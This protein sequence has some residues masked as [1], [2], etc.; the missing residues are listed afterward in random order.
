MSFN[1]SG[2]IGRAPGDSAITLAK[3]YFQP[4]GVTTDFTFSSGYSPGLVDVYRNGVKLIN[5]LDYAATDGSTISLS[6]PVGVGSTVQ[7]VAYK[8]FNLATVKA[9]E[10]DTTVTGTTINLGGNITAANATISALTTTVDLNVSGGATVGGTLVA[11]SFSGDGSALTGIANTAYVVSVATTTGNLNVSAAATITGALTGSTGTFSGAVNVDATT[12]STS[13]TTGALIV[14]GGVGIAKNVYIGAGLS[15]AGTLTYEDVT[16]VD[17]VGLITA[18]SGV[19]ITGGQ[20]TVGSGITMGIAGVATFSGTSD[21]HLLDNVKLNIGDGPDLQLSHSGTNSVID[22]NTGGLYI[23][24]NVGGDVGGDIYIQAKSGENSAIFTHDGSAALHF[25]NAKKFETTN[26]GVVI[27]GIATVGGHIQ[28]SGTD[29]ALTN[30]SQPIIT[31][32]GSSSGSYPF[33]G[34]GHLILQTRGDGTNRDI[35]FA[36]GTSGA[37]K[38]VINSSGYLGIGTITPSSIVH[39]TGDAAASSRIEVD[40]DNGGI[41]YVGSTGSAGYI[42][43]PDAI[44]IDVYTAASKRVTVGSGGD[45][46][47]CGTA[48]GVSSVTWDASANSLIFKDKSYVKFGDSSDLY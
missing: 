48:A 31:R 1:R 39:A 42:Q 9:T 23:R 34:Y 18:K 33:D 47:I 4:T 25:N 16:S 12:D 15:V 35:V 10:L 11:N 43:T 5:V 27:T 32:S 36:T 22:N 8:A 24:N 41:L 19:N 7:V 21:V 46:D 40:R 45:V 2:Y 29:S 6:T 14:D 13:T 17:S 3:Q 20:L 37:N 28:F 38:A 44:P 26:D 30:I